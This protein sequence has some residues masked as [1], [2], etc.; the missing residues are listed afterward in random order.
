MADNTS[1]LLNQFTGG[2]VGRVEELGHKGRSHRGSAL[3]T[4][5][6]VSLG[7]YP[8]W[9]I[10]DATGER[11]VGPFTTEAAAIAEAIRLNGTDTVPML[12]AYFPI[13]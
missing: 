8:F 11:I 6:N 7:A 5:H 4:V 13:G 1:K 10:D 12:E 3:P 9:V 2:L